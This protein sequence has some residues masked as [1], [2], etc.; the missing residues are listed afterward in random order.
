M[1][2]DYLALLAS[3]TRIDRRILY[4]L[5]ALAIVIPLLAASGT[6]VT[7]AAESEGFFRAVQRVSEGQTVLLAAD[8]N[9]AT[10]FELEP[11]VTT[12]VQEVFSRGARLVLVCLDPQGIGLVEAKVQMLADAAGK[13]YGTDWVF[14]GYRPSA[15]GVIMSLAS[16]PYTVFPRDHRG[17]SLRA[18]PLAAGLS[19]H[20][21]YQLVAVVA[22]GPA[23]QDWV[24]YGHARYRAPIV[25]GLGGGLGPTF[26][27]FLDTHAIA[28]LIAG[29]RGAAEYEQLTGRPGEALRAL[30]AQ[31][32]AH[33]LLIAL[34][35]LGNAAFFA[36][37][38]RDRPPV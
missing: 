8:Y 15:P 17:T 32:M 10:A 24:I 34:I 9:G 1:R 25:I 16:A 36:A 26:Q 35:I 28:G 20:S 6:R 31:A 3:L 4:L 37:K 14:L 18:L 11:M 19:G 2:L 7:P 29:L 22:S 27:G 13:T 21:D 5:V 33:L 23:A 30:S 12:L 38:W